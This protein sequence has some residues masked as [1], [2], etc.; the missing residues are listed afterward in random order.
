MGFLFC[1]H[2]N[3]SNL[4]ISFM[5]NKYLDISKREGLLLVLV[6][7]LLDQL[8]KEMVYG[9]FEIGESREVIKGYFNFTL[10]MNPGA[11]FGLFANLPSEIRRVVLGAVT[12]GA[13]SLVFILL[14]NEAK[15]DRMSQICLYLIL[16]GALGNVIDR[17]R[18][19]AVVD[20]LDVYYGTYHWPAFNI[21]DSA[22][23][24][25]VCILLLRLGFFSKKK[26]EAIVE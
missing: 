18:Y 20:F 11:A 14:R 6:V 12:L 1:S 21:A 5:C 17:F 4:S 8:T 16:G 2:C 26:E 9:M 22:I 10:V 13:M 23:S 24:V 15:G 3:V 19:D 25:G 7:F